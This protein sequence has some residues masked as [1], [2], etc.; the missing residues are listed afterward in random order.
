M[1]VQN[2]EDLIRQLSENLS[3]MDDAM[4]LGLNSMINS[5]NTDENS[6]EAVRRPMV[7]APRVPREPR[8]NAPIYEQTGRETRIL[9]P[10][11]P[12]QSSHGSSSQSPV[13]KNGAKQAPKDRRSSRRKFLA[14][15]VIGGGAGVAAAATGGMAVWGLDQKNLVEARAEILRLRGMLVLYESLDKIGIDSIAQVGMATIAA[16]LSGVE[17]GTWMLKNGIE[18]VQ[19]S[20]LIFSTSFPKI[21]DG[22]LWSEEMVSAISRRLQ[23]VEDDIEKVVDWAK[24]VTTPLGRLADSTLNILPNRVE[25]PIRD[26]VAR[27]QEATTSIPQL[28]EQV[29]E[30]LLTPMREEWFGDATAQNWETRLIEPVTISLLE[31]LETHLGELTVAMNEWENSMVQPMQEAIAERQAIREQ[32]AALEDDNYLA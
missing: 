28:V 3:N 19:E 10:T 27:I 5:V 29:N 12:P 13:A 26:A 15:M 31:P 6:D 14:G 23:A 32:I 4:L 9:N 21:R 22:L 30:R 20:L 1:A 18:N 17:Q 16:I 11:E 24:P 2:R 8:V 25:Q 7:V